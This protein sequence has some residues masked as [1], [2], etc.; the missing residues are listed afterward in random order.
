MT[1]TGVKW[2][3]ASVSNVL[4]DERADSGWS[5]NVP[6]QIK[7]EQES[8]CIGNCCVLPLGWNTEKPMGRHNSVPFNP[9]I[10]GVFYRAGYIESWGRGI[11]KICDACKA[12]GTEEPKYY[13]SGFDI[14]VEF[15]ALRS[16]LIDQSKAPKLRCLCFGRTNGA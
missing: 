10:A 15:M 9:K 16:V 6:I 7:I 4:I 1:K 13:V 11:R 12:L 2:E 3:T 14:M 5:M 8:M